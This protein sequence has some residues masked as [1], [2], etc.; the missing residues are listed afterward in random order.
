MIRLFSWNNKFSLVDREK[1]LS[2]FYKLSEHPC[3]KLHTCNRLE[4]YEGDGYIPM[5]VIRHLCRV[6]SGLE[7]SLVGETAIQGQVKEAYMEAAQKY[8]LSKSIHSLFQYA[9]YVGKKVRAMS[10][11]SRGAVSYSQAVLEIIDRMGLNLN[12]SIITLIGAHRLNESIIRYLKAKG[13]ETIFLANRSIEKIYPIAIDYN[14]KIVGFHQLFH[15]LGITDIL[16]SATSA[17]HII[18][19]DADFPDNKTMLIFDLAFPRDIDESIG[20]RNGVI[21]YN[22]EDI[23]QQI[24]QNITQRTKAIEIAEEIIDEAVRQFV[25]KQDHYHVVG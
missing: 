19:K 7:S 2:E 11:I 18:V 12:E 23:E 24:N 20:R 15:V 13:A 10:G 4:I 5:Y 17:P 6:V 8:D 22:L 14:C 3:V 25:K 16:I 1:Y 9:L 21:L